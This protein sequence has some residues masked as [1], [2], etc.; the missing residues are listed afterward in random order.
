M[1]WRYLPLI[2]AIPL[3]PGSQAAPPDS[4]Y[5]GAKACAV[6]HAEIYRKQQ[7]SHHARSLR[8]V[9]SAPE[10]MTRLPFTFQD[11]AGATLRLEKADATAVDLTAQQGSE[12]RRL[13]L[14]WSF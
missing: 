5:A 12:I 9:E 8:A 6:C 7:S 14:Q 3:L 1:N 10:V 13:R 4:G 11:K 2:A